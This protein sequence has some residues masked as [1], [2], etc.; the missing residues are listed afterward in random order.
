MPKPQLM[1][2][3]L[4]YVEAMSYVGVK[5]RT[6]DATWRPRLSALHQGTSLIF[7]RQELD[8]LFEEL[9]TS[10]ADRGPDPLRCS[11]PAHN[12]TRNERPAPMKG[13][14]KWAVRQPGSIPEKKEPGK[15]TS[16]TGTLDFASVVSQVLKRQKAG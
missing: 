2:R 10:E 16:G 11:R 9:K 1:K 13:V 3:G 6:F 14:Q 8:R 12:G 5:R 7:D 15:S 4:S